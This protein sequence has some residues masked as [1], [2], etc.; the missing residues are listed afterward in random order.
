MAEV[1]DGSLRLVTADVDLT[2]AQ[3]EQLRI[4]GGA[5]PFRRGT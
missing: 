1:L 4:A 3:A 2:D 5:G